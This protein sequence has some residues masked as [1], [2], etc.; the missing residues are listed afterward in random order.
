MM[1]IGRAG[2]AFIEMGSRHVMEST[3]I[4]RGRGIRHFYDIWFVLLVDVK[5]LQE[6]HVLVTTNVGDLFVQVASFI[7]LACPVTLKVKRVTEI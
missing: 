5:L 7:R 3:F 6:F 1:S 4:V 2:R